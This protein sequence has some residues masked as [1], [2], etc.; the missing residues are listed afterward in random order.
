MILYGRKGTQTR[1]DTME[2]T[3][4]ID[5]VP[6]LSAQNGPYGRDIAYWGIVRMLST[7]PLLTWTGWYTTHNDLHDMRQD[8]RVMS[9]W[10]ILWPCCQQSTQAGR[11]IPAHAGCRG[12]TTQ[13]TLAPCTAAAAALRRQAGEMQWTLAQQLQ[14]TLHCF[15]MPWL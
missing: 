14:S 8:A 15:Q 6:T 12:G 5:S 7:R 13:H 10:A 1:T 3:V 2:L 4:C 9:P 11:A